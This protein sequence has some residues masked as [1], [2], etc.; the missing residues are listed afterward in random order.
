MRVQASGNVSIGNTNDIYKLDVSGAG[1][2]T[3][4]LYADNTIRLGIALIGQNSNNLLLSSNSAGGEI[5]FYSNALGNKLMTLNGS[6]NLSIGNIND[7]YK[8]DVSG[9]V[10]FTGQLRLQSTITDGTNTYTLPSATGTLAL[11]SALSGYLPLTGG[12]L[13]GALNGTTATFTNNE[14]LRINPA[15]GAAYINFR[16]NTTSY[17]LV[18]IAGA[19]DDII[20]G[21]LTGDLNI[22]ATNS[23]KI[24]FSNNNGASAS[25]TLASSGAAT[26]NATST[27]AGAF[28]S[29]G[30]TPYWY[31]Q[32]SGAGGSTAYLGFGS[33][34]TSGAAS[35]DFI[36]RSENALAFNTNGNNER[37]R[38]TSGGNVGIGTTSPNGKLNI[39]NGGAEGIEFWVLSA[40]ATNLMQSYNRATSAWNSLEYKALDHIFYGSGTERM[41]ITSGGK[42]C[43][44]TTTVNNGAFL[45]I[46]SSGSSRGD[47][48]MTIFNPAVYGIRFLS[49]TGGGSP[50]TSVA[51]M[52]LGNDGTTGRSINASGTI[53][54][55]GLDYAEYMTKAVSE[56]IAK[57]DIIGVDANGLL[58]N[59][60]ADA[61]SFV[62]K[63][64][65]P[66][67]VGGD[68]WGANLKGAELETA[69][70]KVDRVA[71]SGQVPCNVLNAQVGDYIIPINV[72]GKIKGEAVTNPT[73]EQYQISVGKVWK[74]MEDGRAWIA[75]KIG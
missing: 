6:G 23:Q 66:S 69:R 32:S 46:G 55:M 28:I 29:S 12:T 43:I 20:T 49:A 47:D 34:L 1:R 37:M 48:L 26:F 73:F 35:T 36:I 63:S 22:R 4:V 7:T 51:H 53:N 5:G 14:A 45:N 60:Y 25:L 74:I 27:V 24:L 70:Q 38:I 10:R 61:I 39:S 57:G 3:G 72:N 44:N 15:S 21:S 58:T 59:I 56:N 18:G 75:I 52:L 31:F 33:S 50:N 13:T 8:L 42:V 67:Y 2:Y 19:N 30:T 17:S 16:I 41:R 62:V 9:T 54:A 71:F 64:T 11:T 68:K 40:T 65:D